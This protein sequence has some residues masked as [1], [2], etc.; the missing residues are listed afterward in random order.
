MAYIKKSPAARKLLADGHMTSGYSVGALNGF[1]QPNR[2]HFSL[3]VKTPAPDNVDRLFDYVSLNMSRTE[4]TFA[5][6]VLARYLTQSP[7]NDPDVRSPAVA[8]R[9]LADLLDANG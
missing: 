8:L 2:E 3:T 5:A 6:G 1:D 7:G 4:A 9:A